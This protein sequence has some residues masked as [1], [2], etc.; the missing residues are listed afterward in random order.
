MNQLAVI[1]MVRRGHNPEPQRW[2]QWDI[3]VSSLSVPWGVSG[4]PETSPLTHGPC[5]WGKQPFSMW[6]NAHFVCG[7]RWG[8]KYYFSKCRCVS[9]VSELVEGTVPFSW[10]MN[11]SIASIG[12]PNTLKLECGQEGARGFNS[13]PILSLILYSGVKFPD[14]SPLLPDS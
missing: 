4:V 1:E 12:N 10:R 14:F 8:D 9:E 13:L 7:N 6:S 3:L 2:S 5:S 11:L